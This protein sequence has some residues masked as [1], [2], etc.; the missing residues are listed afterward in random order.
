[1]GIRIDP[2]EQQTLAGGSINTDVP[3]GAFG[4]GAARGLQDLAQGASQLGD[5]I[6]RV[7]EDQG[8]IWAA[9]AVSQKELALQQTFQQRVNSLDPTDPDYAKKIASLTED[10][11]GDIE[12]AQTDLMD[13][14]PGRYAKRFVGVHMAN[15]G[16]RLNDFAMR[17]QAQL[18]GDYT[19]GLVQDGIKADSD[20]LAAT[21]DNDTYGRLLQKQ[22]DAVAGLSTIPPNVK[23]DLLRT[24]AHTYANV[25]VASL[26]A[27]NPQAF[28]QVVNAQGGSVNNRGRVTGQVPT[29]GGVNAEGGAATPAQPD[30]LTFA[31][32]QIKA[33][34]SP[35]DAMRALTTKYPDRASQFA[36]AFKDGQFSDLGGAR[37]AQ[38]MAGNP[39][40]LIAPG[41]ID[42]ANRPVAKNADG[43]ISTVRSMSINE[44]GK[45]ILIPTVVGGKVVSN[46]EAI[47]HYH[48]TGENLGVFQTDAQADA[49][50]QSLH[51]QQAGMYAAQDPQSQDPQVQPLNEQDIAKAEPPIAGWSKLTWPEKVSYVRQAEGEVGKQ[52]ASDRGAI[53]RELQDIHASLLAGQ[54]YPGIDSDRYSQANLERVLGPDEGARAAQ[55]INYDR[56][57][58]QFMQTVGTMPAAQREAT[59]AHL[60]PVA[61]EGFAAAEPAYRAAQ[62]AAQRVATLQTTKPIQ[63]AIEAG[64]GGAQPLDFSKPLQDQ[65]VQRAK[66]ANTMMRDYGGKPQIFTDT[67]VK[68]LADNLGNLA[69][70]D[71]INLL[72]NIRQGLNDPR[73]FGQAMNEFAPKNPNLAYAANLAAKGGVSYVDGKAIPDSDIATKIA[74]GD[75]ILNGRKLDQKAGADGEPSMPS[76]SKAVRFKETD[77]Q[78][79][80]NQ[81]LSGAFQSP[82]AQ[83]SA[84]V[85]TDTYNAVKAYYAAESYQKGRSLDAIDP[86]DVKSAIQAVVG[87]PVSIGT[88]KLL[89]PHGMPV[90]QFQNQ[91]GARAKTA[92]IAAGY[93]PETAQRVIDRTTPVN[94]ADGKYGFQNGTRLQ[95]DASG[96][97]VIVDYSQPLPASEPTPLLLRGAGGA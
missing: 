18:N 9:T 63:Y 27:K 81:I 2:Y 55:Q 90:E 77:F 78:N 92:M 54:N 41:N 91:W 52:L 64:I 47:A 94:L 53:S 95:T 8:R 69:G 7:E 33:G 12:Q 15:A 48:K 17:T 11:H 80:F 14:A 36:F 56:Q 4:M 51:E 72:E 1:M 19:K 38:Y 61:G 32:E 30:M 59:L 70:K 57:V 40:G 79:A 21:P 82:D 65:L 76:G 25:Q 34:K 46:E 85:E 28:L 26:V 24:A 42:I 75:I 50:S 62:E 86:N 88:G 93:D 16:L 74:D 84:A 66:V 13:Q 43:S 45:S 5:S 67:E 68:T 37:P 96:R 83:R 73:A 20:I 29:A 23:D 87:T 31:N 71:R 97:P 44:D 39:A 35:E 49:Y 58:G 6:N 89:A 22:H 10:T 60:A 3:A